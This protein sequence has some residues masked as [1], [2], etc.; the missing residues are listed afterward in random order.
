MTSVADTATTT[1]SVGK[2]PA[3][4][5]RQHDTGVRG[6]V[7]DDSQATGT[8]GVLNLA[9]CTSARGQSTDSATEE[10]VLAALQRRAEL[11][12]K[13]YVLAGQKRSVHRCGCDPRR[14]DRAV[15]LGVGERGGVMVSGM[16][17]CSSRW[18]PRCWGLVT[19]DRAHDVQA[20]TR[21]AAEQGKTIA[22]VT[23][24]A[25]H[26]TEQVRAAAEAAGRSAAEAVRMQPLAPL[27][28]GMQTAWSDMISGRPGQALKRGWTGYVR[29]VELTA[30]NYVSPGHRTES[31][32][33]VHWHVV[34][35]LDE[36]EVQ[37]AAAAEA[38]RLTAWADRFS[39]ADLRKPA[40]EDAA[41]A[42]AAAAAE[43]PLDGLAARMLRRWKW[44]C[45]RQ[46]LR[47]EKEGFDLQRCKDPAAAAAYVT[48]GE[49]TKK[50]L[51][52]ELTSSTTKNAGQGRVTPEQI[53]RNLGRAVAQTTG[54]KRRKAS[55]FVH[56]DLREPA[57]YTPAQLARLRAQWMEIESAFDG[58]RW[59]TWSRD[60][61]KLAGLGQEETAEEVANRAVAPKSAN[62]AVVDGYGVTRRSGPDLPDL[63]PELWGLLDRDRFAFWQVK[64]QMDV[65]MN[66]LPEALDA[67]E[68]F[69]HMTGWLDHYGF[70]YRTL[71]WE[72]W[73]L[74]T[75]DALRAEADARAE[76]RAAA[77]AANAP[78]VYAPV[79]AP[80]R[81]PSFP[82]G[83]LPMVWP[84]A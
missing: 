18:C 28:E 58:A 33:H 23:L 30:D 32:Y 57:V 70:R 38:T 25:A 19:R 34:L 17:H 68:R 11:Q 74:E 15:A 13:G 7:L 80:T 40:E 14:N 56:A 47:A 35:I 21:W 39:R 61:R 63:D 44:A 75:A 46:G 3:R 12:E 81:A 16:Q 69:T 48:K 50:Q 42:V 65:Y 84:N 78:A 67:E 29:A 76:R 71:T 2:R 27:L 73:Q 36:D 20:V 9:S 24:T 22:L 49:Q 37:E 53:L 64:R 52:R 43:T 79:P 82:P 54:T 8:S 51:G 59:L 62:V 72:D 1:S 66:T 6:G 77:A 83:T 55:D 60:L 41:A 5:A 4:V 26:V 31:G 10:Q 45:A